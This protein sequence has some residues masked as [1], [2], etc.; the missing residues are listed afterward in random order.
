MHR[1]ITK[2]AGV[3]LTLHVYRTMTNTAKFCST[4]RKI[5]SNEK[6]RTSLFL[7]RAG[8]K[9]SLGTQFFILK[10]EKLQNK[11]KTNK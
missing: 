3:R 11:I 6:H 8:P 5:F 4:K 2:I 10:K 9:I 7:H 1:T